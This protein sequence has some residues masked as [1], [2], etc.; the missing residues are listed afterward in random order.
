M[1]HKWV[2]WAITVAL[3][4]FLSQTGAAQSAD[5]LRALG[6]DVEALKAGQAAL[7]KDLQE[8]KSLLQQGA[9]AQAQAPQPAARAPGAETIDFTLGVAGAPVKGENGAKVTMVEFTDYQ[10]P[11]CSRHFRQVWPQ[12]E[13]DYIKT[14][15]VKL[16]LRDMPLEQIHP[17]ALKAAEAARCAGEQGKYWEMHDRLFANQSAL[18]RKDLTAHAQAVGLDGGAFDQ[19]VDSARETPKVRND[20]IDA[21]RGGARGTP[22]FFLGLTDP[23][24]PDLKA[25]RLI[26]GAQ[27]YAVFKEAIDNLLAAAK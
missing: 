16:V 27:P 8:I 7:Q 21:T 23:N 17:Q 19:C 10:C 4:L 12:I 24:S 18:G 3:G 15:K 13:Q 25:V 14:G 22:V 6:K 2:A 5:E 20:V 9:Q 26:R 11:F 1:T